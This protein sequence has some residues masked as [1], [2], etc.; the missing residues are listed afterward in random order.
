MTRIFYGVQSSVFLSRSNDCNNI[1]ST[2]LKKDRIERDAWY[3]CEA[4]RQATNNKGHYCTI[5]IPITVK[6]GNRD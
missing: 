1:Q 5:M 4:L 3:M 2:D 6:N